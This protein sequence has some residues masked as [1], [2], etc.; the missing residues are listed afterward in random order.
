MKFIKFSGQD[1]KVIWRKVPN[2]FSEKR[3]TR[4]YLENFSSEIGIATRHIE[5]ML[6]QIDTLYILKRIENNVVWKGGTCVQSYVDPKYQRF[7]V[8]LDL[9]TDLDREAVFEAINYINNKLEQEEKLFNVNGIKLGGFTFHSENKIIGVLNFFRLVPFK[10]GGE[11]KFKS[12]KVFDV[13]PIR[14]QLNYGFFRKYGLI[15][16]KILKREPKLA[17]IE[18]IDKP[19]T[20]PHESPEDLLADKLV[21][22]AEIGGVHKGRLRIKDAYDAFIIVKMLKVNYN[23]VKNKLES[24]SEAWGITY[25]QLLEQALASIDEIAGKNLEVL[26][27]KRSVGHLGYSEVILSWK[28]A[29]EQLK[30]VLEANLK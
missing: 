19:F 20:F 3:G 30:A 16:L 15:A 29:M 28:K 13:I 1:K 22:M 18:L 6:W 8:D 27:L 24:I 26:G 10:H 11:Y 12:L 9:N 5:M 2:I 7:S 4:S 17:P 23:G 21:A 14:V 25:K